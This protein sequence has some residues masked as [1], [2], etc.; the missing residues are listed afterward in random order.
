MEEKASGGLAPNYGSIRRVHIADI[1]VG[2][3]SEST[4]IKNEQF[5]N[6]KIF[7][8]VLDK[9]IFR[10]EGKV[11]YGV[12]SVDDGSGFMI[13]VKTWGSSTKTIESI[14]QGDMVDVVGKVRYKDGEIYI[15]PGIVRKID[16]PNW[17]TVREL[18][19]I[20]DHL[21]RKESK[22]A[23]SVPFS[24]H[25]ADLES[26]ILR[27]IERAGSNTGAEYSE[28]INHIEHSSEDE[29]KKALKELLSRGKIY[30]SRPGRYRK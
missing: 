14:G 19:I 22:L 10:S 29:I 23:R 5:T 17:E 18:E 24:R 26:E 11:D 2:G 8:T 13:Q 27:A 16:D 9:K 25:S 3:E 12:I 21:R 30:E 4:I 7:G 1:V 6:V 20:K 15:I 28:L